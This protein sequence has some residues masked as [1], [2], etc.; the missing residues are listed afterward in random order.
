MV[1]TFPITGKDRETM[2]HSKTMTQVLLLLLGGA[3]SE[4]EL[5]EKIRNVGIDE[6]RTLARSF[7]SLSDACICAVGKTA[8]TK[9]YNK[10]V[11][12]GK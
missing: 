7:S 6:I 1:Y 2:L 3:I 4:K 8:G 10:V 11:S 12:A 5:E 9:F